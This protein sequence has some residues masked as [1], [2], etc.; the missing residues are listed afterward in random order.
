MLS[1]PPLPLFTRLIKMRSRATISQVWVMF[2][3]STMKAWCTA[4]V[5][6]M[7]VGMA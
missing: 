7:C 4:H 5:G 3:S 6:Q 2:P 1:L